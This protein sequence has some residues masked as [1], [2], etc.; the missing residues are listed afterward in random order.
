VRDCS[1][2]T[3]H[4]PN[5]A[6]SGFDVVNDCKSDRTIDLPVHYNCIAWAAGDD[7][8]WWWP[9]DLAGYY[10]PEGLPKELPAMETLG[11]FINAFKTVRYVECE[12]GEFE[13]GFE[14]V[15]IFVNYRNKP[16]HAARLLPDGSW[17]SKLGEGEDI[18]HLSLFAL[19]GIRYGKAVAFLKRERNAKD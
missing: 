18:R 15:A 5:L 11:N 10:W 9:W 13:D 1:L 19:E 7:T 6:A 4:F 16:L 14:K 17:T 2:L 3:K 12:N 8:Q